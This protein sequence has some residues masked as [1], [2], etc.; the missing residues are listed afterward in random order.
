MNTA[1]HIINL[2]LIA[3]D[4]IEVLGEFHQ[5]LNVFQIKEGLLRQKIRVLKRKAKGTDNQAIIDG[6]NYQIACLKKELETVKV[7]AR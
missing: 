3:K 5:D 6:F 7:L 2:N 1:N 4:K